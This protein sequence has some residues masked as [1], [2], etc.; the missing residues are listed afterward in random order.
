M[1]EIYLELTPAAT[2]ALPPLRWINGAAPTLP[3]DYSKQMERA[4]ML[5]GAQRFHI[6]SEHPR[7]WTLV[8]E[9]LTS[10]EFADF[11]TLNG[12]NQE[13]HF[14]NNWEDMTWRHVVI[15]G[16]QYDPVVKL[17]GCFSGH[18]GDSA[19]VGRWNLTITLDE[20]S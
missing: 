3:I 12:Y 10:D 15:T 13:L 16:F 8:W 11:L 19:S 20:V 6:K 7:R 1:A 14:Q 5:S 2:V 18:V 17:G 9:M 4:G